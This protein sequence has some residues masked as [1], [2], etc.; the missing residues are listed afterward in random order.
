M[1]RDQIRGKWEEFKGKIK[2]EYGRATADR[3]TQ[4]KGAVQEGG[5]KVQQKIGEAVDA[6]KR[7]PEP[8][9]P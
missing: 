8:A 6:V 9:H 4:I 3:P 7:E 2:K 1:N 5:G